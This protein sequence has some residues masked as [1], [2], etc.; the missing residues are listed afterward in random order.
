MLQVPPATTQ[1]IPTNGS[2]VVVS[3]QLGARKTF[4]YQAVSS[5]RGVKAAGLD[6]NAFRVRNPEALIVDID[7][8]DEVLAATLIRLE[9]VSEIVEGSDRHRSSVFCEWGCKRI[10]RRLFAARTRISSRSPDS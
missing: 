6:P 1:R 2:N 10:G 7:I 5:I 3:A 9:P 8:G 4:Q